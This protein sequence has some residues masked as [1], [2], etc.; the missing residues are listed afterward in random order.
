MIPDA[1]KR[2]SLLLAGCRVP[3][4]FTAAFTVAP[5]TQPAQTR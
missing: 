4:E 5:Y 3:A 1:M 2:M